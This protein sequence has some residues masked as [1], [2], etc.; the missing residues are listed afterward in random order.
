MSEKKFPTFKGRPLVRSGDTIYLGDMRDSHVVKIDIKTKK[1]VDN[2]EVADKV[3]VQ[4]IATDPT[5]PLTERMGK[6]SERNG[7]YLALDIAN[8]WLERKLSEKTTD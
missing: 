3:V 8:A 7:L 4:M 5:L 1:V 2:L 6:P